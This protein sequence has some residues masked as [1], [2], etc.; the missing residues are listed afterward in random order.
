M[1][2]AHPEECFSIVM[3]ES[4]VFALW[5]DL[6]ELF[7]GKVVQFGSSCLGIHYL[8]NSSEGMEKGEWERH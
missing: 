7:W 3:R 4:L 2:A 6:R 1:I 5:D 8:M